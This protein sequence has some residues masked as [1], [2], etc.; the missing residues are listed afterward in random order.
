MGDDIANSFTMSCP[1]T[2][3]MFFDPITIVHDSK[4]C[5]LDCCKVMLETPKCNFR[6]TA[7]CHVHDMP[8]TIHTFSGSSNAHILFCLQLPNNLGA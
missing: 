3:L 2:C 7:P 8:N 1:E 6:N 4:E 5:L